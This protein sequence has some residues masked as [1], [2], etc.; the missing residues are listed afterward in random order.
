MHK[1]KCAS[2]YIIPEKADLLTIVQNVKII[3]KIDREIFNEIRAT[4]NYTNRVKLPL[5]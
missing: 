5:N 2:V 3:R 1:I 4:E